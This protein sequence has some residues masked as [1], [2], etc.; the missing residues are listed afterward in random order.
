MGAQLVVATT[1][2]LP[3][4]ALSQSDSSSQSGVE[5]GRPS[6]LRNFIPA[7]KLERHSSQQYDQLIHQAQSKR[8]LAPANHPQVKRL[9]AIADKIIPFAP[10]FNPRA[11]EGA[12]KLTLV[13]S[14]QIKP[15]VCPAARLLF[16]GHLDTIETHR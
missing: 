10:R 15:F 9:R 2:T 8:A 4:A 12:G 3:L 16:L 7:E 11:K 6:A 14:K 13:G 1:L 5:V